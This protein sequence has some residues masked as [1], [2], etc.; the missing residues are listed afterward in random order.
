MMSI[1]ILVTSRL[2]GSPES[3][4]SSCSMYCEATPTLRELRTDI[5][6]AQRISERITVKLV[7]MRDLGQYAF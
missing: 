5:T 4:A 1:V 3:Y 6:P 2:R 7:K